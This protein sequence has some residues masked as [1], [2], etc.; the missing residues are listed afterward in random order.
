MSQ[1]YTPHEIGFNLSLVKQKIAKQR[2]K[3]AIACCGTNI[4]LQV[5]ERDTLNLLRK[6][7]R[8]WEE[9]ADKRS[10]A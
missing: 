7:L 1:L 9:Y 3:L 4:E 2:K 6:Q 5:I 10:V 8:S